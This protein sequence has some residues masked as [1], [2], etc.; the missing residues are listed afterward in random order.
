MRKK[1]SSANNLILTLRQQHPTKNAEQRK[2][3]KERGMYPRTTP[4][5]YQK[6]KHNLHPTDYEH[7]ERFRPAKTARHFGLSVYSARGPE[8]T[9]QEIC[10]T[11]E[12]LYSRSTR[13]KLI[14]G[15]MSKETI[16]ELGWRP[17]RKTKASVRKLKQ[18]STVNE[19]IWRR[20]LTIQGVE[21]VSP[22]YYFRLV[23]TR[24]CS[25][26]QQK[27]FRDQEWI[28]KCADA[29]NQQSQFLTSE[30]PRHG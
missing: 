4:Q 18:Y 20:R 1:N 12:T 5:P 27:S 21:G 28:Q 7:K 15:G 17:P 9:W 13:S 23:E 2:K 14:E 22:I 11:R 16:L 10:H 24:P 19:K 30:N 26:W 3:K 29:E 8:G 25:E 6:F